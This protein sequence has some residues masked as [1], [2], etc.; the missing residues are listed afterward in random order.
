MDLIDKNEACSF[1]VPRDFERFRA[2]RSQ[3][4][5]LSAEETLTLELSKIDCDQL[6]KYISNIFK[7][8]KNTQTK[9]SRVRPLNLIADVRTFICHLIVNKFKGA[10]KRNEKKDDNNNSKTA[11]Q[12]CSDSSSKR[13]RRGYTACGAKLVITRIPEVR[14][15]LEFQ[16][17]QC[18]KLWDIHPRVV[19]SAIDDFFAH[20]QNSTHGDAFKLRSM[21]N[22]IISKQFSE[23]LIQTDGKTP[24]LTKHINDRHAV[25]KGKAPRGDETAALLYLKK[26]HFPR[27]KI[28]HVKANSRWVLAY[29]YED[30]AEIFQSTT[31][32]VAIGLDSSHCFAKKEST[33][34]TLLLSLLFRV[35]TT[36]KWIILAQAYIEGEDKASLKKFLK[37]VN[38]NTNGKLE[39]ITI[40]LIDDSMAARAAFRNMFPHSLIFFCLWHVEETLKKNL[41]FNS[42]PNKHRLRLFQESLEADQNHWNSIYRFASKALF[43]KSSDKFQ[44][45]SCKVIELIQA[46]QLWWN[47]KKEPAQVLAW[48]RQYLEKSEF[49]AC[50]S[51]NKHQISSQVRTTG[52]NESLHSHV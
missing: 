27:S 22:A 30:S 28:L 2:L 13:M 14:F 9:D 34:N 6:L 46:T 50:F 1:L 10:D 45:Y 32:D 35:P 31:H 5:N 24:K 51:R 4:L 29:I 33:S 39:T 12:R 21:C 43:T 40:V 25:F 38:Q 18:N 47:K 7:L 41:S 15:R 16:G 42:L 3:I 8:Q 52:N 17:H 11:S 26:N 49:W 19:T 20:F 37:Y 23:L 36:L 44:K 48:Y